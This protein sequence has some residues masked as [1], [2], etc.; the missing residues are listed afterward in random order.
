MV[1]YFRIFFATILTCLINV[2][3]FSQIVDIQST[4]E[5]FLPPRMTTNQRDAIQSPI[6]GM[7]VY[8]KTTGVINYFESQWK[9]FA[10]P[11]EKKEGETPD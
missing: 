11:S 9:E 6:D 1:N 2:S 4:N 3:V 7:I 5:G 10:N 8:N